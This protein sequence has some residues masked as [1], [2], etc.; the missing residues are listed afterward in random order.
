[1]DANPIDPTDTTWELHDPTYRVYFW[2]IPADS[3]WAP[4]S[5][6]WRIT[7]ALDE[8]EGLDWA[9]EQRGE[10]TFELFVE[11]TERRLG[12]DGWSDAPGLIR[13]AGTSPVGSTSATLEYRTD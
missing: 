13:L 3:R 8:Q 5:F 6:E 7:N 9:M 11:H 1:M 4:T 10:R 2:S 12:P